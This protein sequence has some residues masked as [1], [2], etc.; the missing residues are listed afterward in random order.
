MRCLV[1][2]QTDVWSFLSRTCIPKEDYLQNW[3][4]QVVLGWTKESSMTYAIWNT[5]VESQGKHLTSFC[6]GEFSRHH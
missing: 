3:L 6:L 2:N 1:L 4:F 5:S